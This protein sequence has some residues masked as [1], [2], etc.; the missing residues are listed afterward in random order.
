MRRN[1]DIMLEKLEVVKFSFTSYLHCPRCGTGMLFI[2]NKSVS[3]PK[4][5]VLND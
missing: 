4:C 3:C 5:E 2:D 1:D